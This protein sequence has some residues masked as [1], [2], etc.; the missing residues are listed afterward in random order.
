MLEA[1]VDRLDA[2]EE[3]A[4]T[5]WAERSTVEVTGKTKAGGW[6]LHALTGDE[7]MLTL[8]FR[9]GKNTFDEQSLSRD[10]D[11]AD[12]N[13]LDE[14]PVYNRQPRVRIRPAANGPFED[15]TVVLLKPADMETPEFERFFAKAQKSFL[16]RS[17]PEKLDLDDL[18]PWKKLGRKWHLMRK[19]FLAGRVEWDVAVL[20]QLIA[21]V[22]ELLPDAKV[23]WTQKVLVNFAVDK[24]PVVTIV[25]KRPAGV[26]FNLFVPTGT[27]QLGQIASLGTEPEVAPH[28]DGVDVVRLRFTKKDQVQNATFKAFLASQVR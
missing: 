7:W 13:D 24:R 22:E 12:V 16:E 9:V 11:L 21:L 15:V 27:V 14:I 17:D 20:E 4:P 6:F 1:I 8:K 28:K 26:D 10:L 2:T 18:T 5:N 19:G 23:D 25:T 3:F